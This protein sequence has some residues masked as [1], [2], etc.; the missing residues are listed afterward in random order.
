ML[1]YIKR[2]EG[3][4]MFRKKYIKTGLVFLVCTIIM[5]GSNICID[6]VTAEPVQAQIPS[7]VAEESFVNPLNIV[8]SPKTY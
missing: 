3:N 2:K 1:Q 7:T 8:N 4:I 6:R 5:T